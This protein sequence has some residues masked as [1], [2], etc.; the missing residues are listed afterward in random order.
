M[1]SEEKINLVKSS[2]MCCVHVSISYISQYKR[3]ISWVR[4]EAEDEG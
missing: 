2:F 3:V 1:M 4:E